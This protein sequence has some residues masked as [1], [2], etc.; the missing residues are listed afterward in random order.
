LALRHGPASTVNSG[1]ASTPSWDGGRGGPAARSADC[2]APSEL[3]M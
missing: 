2:H 1:I 3:A